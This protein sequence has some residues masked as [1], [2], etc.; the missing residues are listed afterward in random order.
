MTDA[1]RPLLISQESHPSGRLLLRVSGDLDHHTSS[2]LNQAVAGMTFTPAADVI[3]DLT[4][5]EYCDSTGLTALIST[6]QRA[7]A[8][9]ATLCMAG[10]NSG[11]ERIVRITGLDQVFV[12]YPTVEEALAGLRS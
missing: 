7:Q 8:A 12:I 4:E 10:L 1:E 5:L 3:V 2:H 6:Y 11:L 9:G